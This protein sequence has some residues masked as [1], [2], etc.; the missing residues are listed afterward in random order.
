MSHWC[1]CGLKEVEENA[2]HALTGLSRQVRKNGKNKHTEQLVSS[3]FIELTRRTPMLFLL[4]HIF[5]DK[6]SIEVKN[7][8]NKTVL[9]VFRRFK[10][11]LRFHSET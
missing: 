6:T 9:Y 4:E 3:G 5:H 2:I 11:A 8:K 1:I 10:Q 7:W